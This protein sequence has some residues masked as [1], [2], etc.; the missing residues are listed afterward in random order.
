[1]TGDGWSSTGA[2]AV[3]QRAI[4][5]DGEPSSPQ[6]IP[7]R[8]A[9][10]TRTE[11]TQMTQSR[12]TNA[13]RFRGRV[14]CA[15]GV[16]RCGHVV[17]HGLWRQEMDLGWI[18]QGETPRRPHGC[19]TRGCAVHGIASWSQWQRVVFMKRPQGRQAEKPPPPSRAH[20]SHRGDGPKSAGLADGPKSPQRPCECDITG[21]APEGAFQPAVSTWTK[22]SR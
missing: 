20:S 22:Q 21:P 5:T 2:K 4:V 11:I 13:E 14:R 8:S 7:A 17:G 16:D 18:L 19:P 10:M 1:M 9:A 12:Q 6:C 3:L 15:R